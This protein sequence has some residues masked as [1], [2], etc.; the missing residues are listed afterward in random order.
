M[1]GCL[2]AKIL[3]YGD[4]VFIQ[5]GVLFFSKGFSGFL[6]KGGR[7]LKADGERRGDV[8]RKEGEVWFFDKKELVGHLS[9]FHWS[10]CLLLFTW[11]VLLIVDVSRSDWLPRERSLIFPFSLQL[12][13]SDLQR[14]SLGTFYETDNM[15]MKTFKI[16][17]WTDSR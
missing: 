5:N 13:S 17:P 14:V 12:Q 10:M 2:V 3:C 9:H 11:L 16:K 6:L 7:G 4:L 15:G 1:K 8:K